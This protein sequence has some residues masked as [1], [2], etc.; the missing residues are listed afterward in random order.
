MPVGGFPGITTNM[1][2]AVRASVNEYDKSTVVSIYPKDINE[3]KLTITPG[4]FKIKAGSYDD[5]SMLAVGSSSWWKETDE[6][7]PLLEIPQLS[8]QVADSIVKDYCNGLLGCNMSTSMPGLF[9]VPGEFK[10]VKDLK[11]KHQSALDVA[12]AKQTTFWKA[13]VKFADTFWARTNG[14]PLCISDEMRMA[15][16]ELGLDNKEW[17]RDFATLQMTN[18]K[19][20][21]S[22]VKPG[23]PVCSNCKAIVDEVKAKELNIKF[24]T[25]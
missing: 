1:R 20:C 15:A 21:G 19:A 22:L 13:L 24:A 12:R 6:D 16:R 23:Y 7:Q 11:I 8:H 3:K 25:V 2:R 18:C 5:P 14:N 4:I 9:W 10:S 17:M